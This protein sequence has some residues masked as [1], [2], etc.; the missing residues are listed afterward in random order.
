MSSCVFRPDLGAEA[1]TTI[2]EVQITRT[3]AEGAVFAVWRRMG[4]RSWVRR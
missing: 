4:R 2:E 3:E 1:S